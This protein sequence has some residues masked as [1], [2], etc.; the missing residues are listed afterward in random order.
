M[1]MSFHEKSLWL[2]LISLVAV[3]GIYFATVLPTQTSHVSP[4]QVA[5][6]TAAVVLLVLLQVIGHTILAIVERRQQVDE[7][8]RLIA[9]K[10]T[11]NG[12]FVLGSGVFLALCT[13]VATDGNF[14]FTHVLLGA[15][16]AAQAVDIATQLYLQRRGM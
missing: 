14:A 12:A 4:D 1:S 3:F 7:R 11:R 9:L 10:G 6:F 15:W 13:A 16:V 8:D 5:A 2:L